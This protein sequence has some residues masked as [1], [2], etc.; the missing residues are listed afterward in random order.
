VLNQRL[1]PKR[2]LAAMLDLVGELGAR[3]VI[4]AHSG[5]MLGLLFAAEDAGDRDRLAAAR[6][7]CARLPG[8]LYVFRSL[9]APDVEHAHAA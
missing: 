3:G 2:N 5:T 9:S 8:R 1:V 4:C 7:A 6:V